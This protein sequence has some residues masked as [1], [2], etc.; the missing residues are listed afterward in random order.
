MTYR[1]LTEDTKSA[2]WLHK[3]DVLFEIVAPDGKTIEGVACV[4]GAGDRVIEL[5]ETDKRGLG[6]M[7][8]E[9]VAEKVM[10]CLLDEVIAKADSE[11]TRLQQEVE[12]GQ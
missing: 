10:L 3:G 1:V 2:P 9:S 4:R 11:E 12:E 7:M 6:P 8:C 5:V